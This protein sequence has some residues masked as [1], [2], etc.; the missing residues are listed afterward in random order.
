MC[1]PV[2]QLVKYFEWTFGGV[3]LVALK[4]N[5]FSWNKQKDQSTDRI[6]NAVPLLMGQYALQAPQARSGITI[7]EEEKKIHLSQ[8]DLDVGY[9]LY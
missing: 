1:S 5:Y 8:C 3:L 2:G 7:D 6:R 4:N 9:M